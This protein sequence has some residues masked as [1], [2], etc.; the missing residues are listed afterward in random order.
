MKL[1]NLKK[2]MWIVD[3][4]N[5]YDFSQEE[6]T[7]VAPT[8]EE[9]LSQRYTFSPAFTRVAEEN[10]GFTLPLMRTIKLQY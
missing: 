1:E 6:S 8:K 2:C 7:N 10:F 9:M 5:S 4:Y 3:T